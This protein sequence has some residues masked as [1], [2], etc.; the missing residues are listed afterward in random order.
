MNVLDYTNLVVPVTKAKSKL[1]VLDYDYEPLNEI[2]KNNWEACKSTMLQ[3]T[4]FVIR[5][6]L[7]H[8]RH[9]PVAFDGAPAA[10]QILGRRLEEEKILWIASIVVEALGKYKGRARP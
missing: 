2:D 4:F 6:H 10:V 8:A 9:D 5:L 7:I 3:A 1:D